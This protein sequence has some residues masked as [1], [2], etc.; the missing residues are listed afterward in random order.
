VFVKVDR[1]QKRQ[2]SGRIS[3]KPAIG[4]LVGLGFVILLGRRKGEITLSQIIKK[5]VFMREDRLAKE[6]RVSLLEIF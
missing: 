5:P 3:L 1:A 2:K 4:V 6:R